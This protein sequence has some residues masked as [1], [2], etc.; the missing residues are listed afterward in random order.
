MNS[1]RIR[2]KLALGAV[3]GLAVAGTALAATGTGTGPSTNTEP[4]VLPVADGV[5]VTSLLTV[6]TPTD[7]GAASDGYQMVGI[8]DGLGAA[9]GPGGRDF[10]V[11]MN[12]EL[13]AEQGIARRH[14]QTGAF[15]S[16]LEIDAATLEVEHGQDLVDPGVRYWNY[17][18][19]EYSDTPS[20]GHLP[21]FARWCSSFL[22]E[23]GQLFN[24]KTG[25][26]YDG[27]LY[28]GN[29]ENGDGGRSF[30]VTTGGQAQ[31]LPRLGLFN[32]EN[33]VV[34][35]NKGDVTYTQGQEDT[36]GG[37]LWVYV[38]RKRASG[39]AFDRA[40][41]TNGQDFVVDL[42]NEAV[43]SD[44]EFR[45]TY[46]KNNPAPFDLGPQEEVDWDQTGPAQ[47]A[48]A[49][50]KGLTLN[51]IEDGAFD[52]RHPEDFYFVSTEGS[53]GTVPGSSPPVSRDGGGVWRLSYDDVER[54]WKGGTLTLLLDGTEAPFLNKPDNVGFDEFGH[55]LIQ[56]DPGN[57][58][59]LARIVAYDVDTGERAVLAQFDAALFAP[60]ATGT[61]ATTDEES[62]GIIDASEFLGEGAFLFDAQVHKNHPETDKVEYG[63]LMT[64]RVPDWD[65]VFDE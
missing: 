43:D 10:T 58:A 31:H 65:D 41:L 54:P 19:G 35:L 12:H 48:E 59:Q 60:G 4:Y 44:G 18:T 40:G 32:W 3:L 26:G 64:L 47:N 46:G 57:N 23:P 16:K 49:T 37:Q 21:Q 27:Q 42:Q 33:T 53:P 51:R 20:A 11:F 63:Q 6:E 13:R 39:N 15:A 1:R 14:G 7:V 2:T 17:T 25:H 28:F 29:E 55:L 9:A 22:S 36:A 45:T 52:P 24:E 8:P 38:G 50:A 56:E 62:S 5:E 61:V 30:G 34:G